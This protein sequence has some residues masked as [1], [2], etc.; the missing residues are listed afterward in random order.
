MIIPVR[1]INKIKEMLQSRGVEKYS[2][3]L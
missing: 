1:V 3:R 2:F